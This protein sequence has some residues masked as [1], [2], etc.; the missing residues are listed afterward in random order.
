MKS[1]VGAPI[2]RPN[3]ENGSATITALIVVGVAAVLIAGMMWREE[4]Q[5][6][7]LE[8]AR[9]RTQ[10]SW[11]QRAAVDFARLVL[12]EDQKNSQSD[13]LGEV[14]ALPLIDSKVADFLKNADVPDEISKVTVLGGLT[15]AQ[16]LFNLTNLWDGNFKSINSSGVQEYARLLDALGLDRNI[17]QKTAQLILDR[18][19]K[20]SDVE[21]LSS[22]SFYNP[23]LLMQL[24]PY[25]TILPI[26]TKININTATPEVLMAALPGLSR[27]SADAFV[28]QRNLTPIQSFDGIASLLAKIGV[29]QNV[30]P[31]IDLMDVKSQFWLAHSEI[32]MQSGKFISAALI[33]R[34]TTILPTGDFTQVIW[35]RNLRML[36][37]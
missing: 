3:Q 34:S 29:A 9:D 37:E 32:R 13:H 33:Q 4:F 25:I 31:S 17:A 21:S 27:E 12:V 35:N 7:A 1:I 14:W 26:Q 16:G 19:M 10:A 24:S 23:S 11:L 6:R 20:L 22:L 15:D 18:G 30:L 8:N 28:K 36:Q 2:A 5:I